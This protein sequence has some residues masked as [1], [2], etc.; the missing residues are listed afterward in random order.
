[1]DAIKIVFQPGPSGLVIVA[2]PPALGTQFDNLARQ[3]H[4]LRPAQ[5]AADELLLYFADKD[6]APFAPITLGTDNTYT[7]PNAL[8]Q[9]TQLH[10]QAAFVRQGVEIT[11]TNDIVLTLRLSPTRGDAPT[12]LP[13]PLVQLMA[14]AL[15]DV[16]TAAGTLT[17]K[18]M[19]G[20]TVATLTAPKGE[21]GDKGDKGE[22]GATG[23][24][25][26]K[27]PQGDTGAPG[28]DGKDGRDGINGERGPAGPA[29]DTIALVNALTVPVQAEGAMATLYP[30][31]GY[32]LDIAVS[33][34]TQESGTDAKSPDN[35]HKLVGAASVAVQITGE[36][37]FNVGDI[38]T[39][40]HS[41]K[42]AEDW[43]TS[44][45]DNTG[46][47][48]AVYAN[49][50]TRPLMSL[51][52]GRTYTLIVEIGA[53]SG[54]G[55]YE[56]RAVG[57]S[58]TAAQFDAKVNLVKPTV[59]IYRYTITPTR[60]Y[61]DSAVSCSLRSYVTVSAGGTVTLTY[62]LSVLA[63][64]E[65]PTDGFVYAPHVS[66]LYSAVMPEPLYG[67]PDARDTF[68]V[69]GTLTKRTRCRTL[70]GTEPWVLHP[71]GWL[72]APMEAMIPDTILCD[73]LIKQPT[74]TAEVPGDWI[75]NDAAGIYLAKSSRYQTAD[76]LKN[77]LTAEAAKGTP[78]T[79]VYALGTPRILTTTPL[80]IPG[81][82]GKNHVWSNGVHIAVS[83]RL[84]PQKLAD[85]VSKLTHATLAL[86]ASV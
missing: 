80:T 21:Q 18:N 33:C 84:N 61:K 4:F 50:Y 45:L 32:P 11:R 31:P 54:T 76:A 83:A 74:P 68:A 17:L 82:T 51:V 14:R 66:S 77:W 71:S 44:S 24:T 2:D 56:L 60:G 22:S 64:A 55:T 8:T 48:S 35:P 29:V 41:V 19:A 78:L 59:G 62:R 53:A 5:H 47:A 79:V 58:A 28:K 27:G 34:Q 67:L 9:S 81:Q 16:E 73:R 70:I 15:C 26:D 69:T 63:D 25:G 49:W 6:L 42:N 75:A 40:S 43:I 1:M 38:Y 12:P 3:I 65:V 46:G 10:L 20:S 39:T 36:N 85:D 86:G 30:L 57:A 37:L 72:Y 13:D 52:P 23:A 7:V